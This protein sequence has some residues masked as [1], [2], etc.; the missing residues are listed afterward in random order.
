MVQR[1]NV[2]VLVATLSASAI[3]QTSQPAGVTV[4]GRVTVTTRGAAIPE[5]IVYLEST[6]PAAQFAIPPDAEISQKGAQFSPSLLIVCV[7]QTVRFK[8][9]E[10]T[11]L[12]HNVFS[13]APAQPFDLGLYQPPEAK[14]VTFKIPGVVRIYCSI[15]RLMDGVIFVCPTPFWTRVATD[16]GFQIKNVPPGQWRLKTWQRNQ[17]YDE[18]DVAVRTDGAAVS[19][20]VQLSRQ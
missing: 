7:G 18:Q 19:A 2:F 6:D 20:D 4:Q 13:Q 3:A 14:G 17:K 1:A 9:D 11:P 10:A 12:Q 15:H 5:M 16:G 8:N